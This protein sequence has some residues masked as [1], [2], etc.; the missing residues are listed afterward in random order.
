MSSSRDR[1]SYNPRGGRP[2]SR[3][4]RVTV[5]VRNEAGETL[6]VKH[7]RQDDW[8]LP[9]GRAV[10]GEDPALRARLEVAEEVGLTIGE[11]RHA[12]RYVGAHAVHRVYVAE[13]S[14]EP[15][16]HR[17][18]LQDAVWWDGVRPLDTQPHVGAILALVGGT[19]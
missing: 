12:G 1:H 7:N 15:R 19:R 18:E 2:K 9:G 10:A 14:G 8:A 11:P 4:M 3:Y 17:S 13:A 5:V 6:L 16:P